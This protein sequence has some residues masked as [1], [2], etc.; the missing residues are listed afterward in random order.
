MEVVNKKKMETLLTSLL[1]Y[2]SFS[3][4]LRYNEI[5]TILFSFL[6]DFKQSTE[7]HDFGRYIRITGGVSTGVGLGTF[8]IYVMESTFH[9]MEYTVGLR[10]FNTYT[11]EYTIYSYTPYT[12]IQLL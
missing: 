7:K 1:L 9:I 5:R 11:I 4:L 12:L 2:N 8:D 3:R 10:M 6:L